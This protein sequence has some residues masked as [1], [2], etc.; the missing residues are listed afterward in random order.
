MAL[1]RHNIAVA[2]PL[3]VQRVDDCPLCKQL[4]RAGGPKDER[5]ILEELGFIVGRTMTGMDVQQVLAIRDFLT[6]QVSLQRRQ[7]EL[8]GTGEGGMTALYSAA[9]DPDISGVGVINY[10][11][12]RENAWEE[13]VDRMLYGQLN[14]FGDAEVAALV[15]SRPLDVIYTPAGPTPAPSVASEAAR[16]RKFYDALKQ[17]GR[18]T[19]TSAPDGDE[20]EQAV[21]GIVTRSAADG[22]QRPIRITAQVARRAAEQMAR[23]ISRSCTLT[24]SGWIGKVM[25]SGRNAGNCSPLPSHSVRSAPARC[26]KSWPA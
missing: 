14:E 23:T 25:P 16:A 22:G 7:V 12:R 11:D 17:A 15:A 26:A 10:F 8:L 3:L 2:I 13:P 20:L 21:N 9:V 1:L 19:V 4:G 18:F 5:R 24:F 6:S